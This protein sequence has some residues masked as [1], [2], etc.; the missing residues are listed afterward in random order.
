MKTNEIN[1]DYKKK[2][3]EM[4]NE[5]IK[6]YE[7]YG[8]LLE[9]NNELWDKYKE[10]YKENKDVNRECINLYKEKAGLLEQSHKSNTALTFDE[11]QKKR[12]D[13]IYQERYEEVIELD[14]KYKKFRKI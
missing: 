1:I 2:Y 8:N 5:N 3:D 7:K 4:L 12:D 11:Y 10:L 6:L 9:S 14:K 13:L